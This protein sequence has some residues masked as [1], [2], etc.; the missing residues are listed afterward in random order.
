MSQMLLHVFVFYVWFIYVCIHLREGNV[1]LFYGSFTVFQVE[2]S[3][4]NVTRVPNAVSCAPRREDGRETGTKLK[5]T[6][7]R[8]FIR[9]FTSS[10][11]SRMPFNR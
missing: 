2:W 5:P 10:P 1:E 11:V 4:G 9:F 3:R 8:D 7:P 6:P